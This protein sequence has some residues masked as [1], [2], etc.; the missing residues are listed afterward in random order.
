MKRNRLT[1]LT[2]TSLIALGMAAP[3]A[4]ADDHG[5]K[6]HH[7][8]GHHGHDDHRHHDDR[9]HYDDHRAP[10]P[11]VVY[12]PAPPPPHAWARGERYHDYYRGPVV[13]VNDYPRYH[14]RRPPRGYHW[15]RDDRGNLLMVAIASGII[16]DLVLHH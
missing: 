3:A 5:H 15:V 8:N 4:F 14:V 9:G 10:P 2:L 1:V 7:D 16:A 6:D 12:R 13:V 11:R